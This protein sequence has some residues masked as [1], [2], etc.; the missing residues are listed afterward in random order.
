M[1]KPTGFWSYTSSDDTASRGRLSQL[2]RLL[3]DEL[4]L[5]IGRLPKV[6]IFQ[7]VAAI[8]HGTDWLKEIHRALDDSSFL[9]PIVT[10]AFLQSEMCCAEV[11][12]FR[13]REMELGRD[14]LIF[15]FHYIG[16]EDVDPDRSSE[17]HDAAVLHLLRSRQWIDF[18]L[19]RLRNP[20]GE[21][22][23]LKLET[24]ADSLRAALRRDGVPVE[25]LPPPA[26]GPT[27]A[28]PS[29]PATPA[30]PS[31]PA[32]GSVIRDGPAYPE[33][34]WISPGRF[35]MGV[36]KE[37]STREGWDD[38]NA[39][40]QHKVTISRGFH[41]GKYPVT[42]GE[43]TAFVADTGRDMSARGF[44]WTK[45]GFEQTD[46]HPVVCVSHDDATAYAK[47]L[48]DK[49]GEAYRLPSEAEWEYAA[50]AGTTT[51][52]F[53]GDGW[54]DA[55]A[56][57]NTQSKGT[58]A[59]GGFKPNG[60]GLYDMLGNVWEW[61]ADHWHQPYAGAPADGSPWTSGGDAGRRVV[62]GGSWVINP[63]FLRAGCRVR[64]D[65]D[66]RVIYFGFRL[67][68]TRFSP[69]S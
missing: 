13:Q 25:V 18:R 15:P 10:P 12:R 2:R 61:M 33:M 63:G 47:W 51:A 23:A 5:K 66:D 21:D 37:E 58:T 60:F 31:A 26:V 17:C 55:P 39:R 56:Y 8:P 42:R 14:D 40:P 59:V 53:W 62:R 57:A 36:P 45:P 11:A 49:T 69:E 35:V 24:L 65:S 38:D 54:D 20:D 46:R 7:D 43:F 30:T 16:V 34:V 9:I 52:H 64:D 4:Q 22:V 50:R 68:R 29:T 3:A 48:S 1:L 67:A 32:P 41:L 28:K 44:D 27:Q 19:L 6:H